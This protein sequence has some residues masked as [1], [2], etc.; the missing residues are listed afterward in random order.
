MDFLIFNNKVVAKDE[1]NLTS[2]FQESTFQISQKTWFGFGGI[3]LFN[4][5]IESI[6]E[7]AGLLNFTVPKEFKNTMELFRLT[8]RMLNKNK[9][10]RSGIVHFRILETAEKI[11]FIVTSQA[12]EDFDFPFAPHGLLLNFSTF[13]KYSQNPFARFAFFNSA[14]WKTVTSGTQYSIFQNSIILNENDDVCECTGSNIFMI[15]GNTIFSPS[16]KTGCYQDILR[17]FVLKAA[18]E[19]KLKVEEPANVK[20]KDLLQMD[21][22]FIASE[23]KGFQWILGIENK[24]YVHYFSEVIHEKLNE[25]LQQKVN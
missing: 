18:Q 1:V 14:Y 13:K 15:R 4:E 20:K 6:L 19:I 3:P 22:I 12:F 5:N 2:A 7:Q 21:E 25:F 11:S 9:F 8:K 24:R 10:Y 16:L 17:N 23:E